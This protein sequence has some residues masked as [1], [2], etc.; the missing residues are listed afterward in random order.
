DQQR[1]SRFANRLVA[2]GAVRFHKRIPGLGMRAD[3]DLVAAKAVRAPPPDLGDLCVRDRR[4]DGAH[5]ALRQ[6]FLNG[7]DILE[8][9][10]VSL[11]PYV[12]AAQRVDELAGDSNSIA[13]LADA[14]FENVADAQFTAHLPDVGRLAFV[15]E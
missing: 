8:H 6:F 15:G 1:G 12:T 3:R 13:R 4:F 11:R 7:K 10:V 9:A 5:D 2:D 14:A